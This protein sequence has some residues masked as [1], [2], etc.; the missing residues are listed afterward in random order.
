MK[1]FFDLSSMNKPIEL[2]FLNDTSDL[3][4]YVS[5]NYEFFN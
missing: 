4:F 2:E 1:H 3:I 5:C